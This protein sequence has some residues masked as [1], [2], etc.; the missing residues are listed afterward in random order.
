MAKPAS[1]V[2][3]TTPFK[4]LPT[5]LTAR[6]LCAWKLALSETEATILID[7]HPHRVIGGVPHVSKFQ[8]QPGSLALRFNQ[9]TI[10]QAARAVVG[11]IMDDPSHP[12]HAL[13]KQEIARVLTA[14]DGPATMGDLGRW[15]H[16][17]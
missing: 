5:W 2:H 16:R 6:D 8:F 9:S 14:P 4:K 3:P 10:R 13:L 7:L 1:L 11:M 17:R 15:A 12:A